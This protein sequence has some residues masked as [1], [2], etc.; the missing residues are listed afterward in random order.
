M[1]ERHKWI[2]GEGDLKMNTAQSSLKSLQWVYSLVEDMEK[3]Q[4]S[5]SQHISWLK[6]QIAVCIIQFTNRFFASFICS[7]CGHCLQ[8]RNNK[9]NKIEKQR[10]CSLTSTIE[11]SSLHAKF[12]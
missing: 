2:K 6:V 8:E 4:T 12:S 1:T 9:N 5:S 10:F 3:K 11:T 7:P